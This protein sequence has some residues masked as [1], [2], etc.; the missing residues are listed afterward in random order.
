[1]T[2]PLARVA[3]DKECVSPSNH[4]SLDNDDH[5]SHLVLASC[6]NSCSS[7]RSAFA[8]WRTLRDPEIRDELFA[9]RVFLRTRARLLE[10]GQL[11]GQPRAINDNDCILERPGSTPKAASPPPPCRPWMHTMCRADGVGGVL[12]R[13]QNVTIPATLLA[14]A[15]AA[16]QQH[17]RNWQQGQRR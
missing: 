2:S 8:Y 16:N 12:W 15:A 7:S 5:S 10:P 1:M 3:N 11:S 6:T 17:P 14:Y 4:V 9:V 13:R